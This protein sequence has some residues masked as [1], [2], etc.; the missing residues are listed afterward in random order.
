MNNIGKLINNLKLLDVLV[1][2]LEGNY[3][4][5]IVFFNWG[6]MDILIYVLNIFLLKIIEKLCDVI[7]WFL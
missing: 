5:K 1:V 4:S 3:I 7:C 2:I 6:L